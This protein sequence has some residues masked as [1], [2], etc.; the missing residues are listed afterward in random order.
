MINHAET[1]LNSACALYRQRL[2][3][4]QMDRVDMQSMLHLEYRLRVHLHV[5]AHESESTEAEPQTAP[6]TFVYL[7]NRLSSR[8]S[9]QQTQA[10]ELACQ[11][12]GEDTAR[13]DIVNWMPFRPSQSKDCPKPLA[14]IRQN[15]PSWCS[16]ED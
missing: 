14:S 5:L 10:A 3:W 7:A 1:H 13:P 2:N 11:M 4:M 9:T 16:S 15:C 6:D 8:D 12:L